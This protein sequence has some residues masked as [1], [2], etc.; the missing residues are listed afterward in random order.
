MIN[1]IASYPKSGNT[2]LRAFLDAYYTGEVNLQEL[3]T[4]PADSKATLYSPGA[5]YPHPEKLPIDQQHLLRGVGLFRYWKAW[6]QSES[7]IPLYLKTHSVNMMINGV[8]LIPKPITKKAI[9]IV[10]DPRDILPSF[11]K[12]MGIDVDTAINWMKNEKRILI[13]KE[14]MAEMISSWGT[15]VKYW[16]NDKGLDVKVV[17]FEDMKADPNYT[18][19]DI[20]LFL[21]PEHYQKGRDRVKLAKAIELS[22]IVNLKK[23][24]RQTGF[25]ESSP[26]QKNQF[27]SGGGRVGWK[28]KIT[29][30]QAGAI[31]KAFAATM[32]QHGYT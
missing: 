6:E 22:G 18:F 9:Y 12:H 28:N 5:V 25:N 26:F 23:L 7:P 20:L 8:D 15:H 13:G 27:F 1:W 16:T 14:Q 21:D 3:L 19:E 17:R 10:R 29:A 32:K 30:K 24:E 11:A 31:K 4:C 2:W